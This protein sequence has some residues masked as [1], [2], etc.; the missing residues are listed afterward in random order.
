MTTTSP[1]I[2]IA[3]D[4][5]SFR[6]TLQEVLAPTGLR[7]YLAANGEEVL[8]IVRST[9]VHLL[10]LDMH[11]PRLTGLETVRRIQQLK[12]RIPFIILS[13]GI[14]DALRAEAIAAHAF[15]VLSKPVDRRTIMCLVQSALQ[16]NPTWQ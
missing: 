11:M 9:E 1:S 16:S 5:S 3:D 2:L 15:S 10:L 13:A 7:T 4:D 6:Q 12:R 14:D 8:R